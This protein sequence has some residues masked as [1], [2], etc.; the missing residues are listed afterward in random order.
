M[1][2]TTNTEPM[3][4]V[5]MLNMKISCICTV[6]DVDITDNINAVSDINMNTKLIIIDIMFSVFMVFEWCI[7]SAFLLSSYV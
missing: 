3:L 2:Y 4:N 6:K 7:S 5:M 1:L